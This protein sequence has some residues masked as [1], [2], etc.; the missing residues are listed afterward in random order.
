MLHPGGCWLFCGKQFLNQ[1]ISSLRRSDPAKER[2]AACFSSGQ[3]L[4]KAQGATSPA[5]V[6]AGFPMARQHPSPPLSP[7]FSSYDCTRFIPDTKQKGAKQLSV[8][9][10]GA[11]IKWFAGEP[12]SATLPIADGS[13]CSSPRDCRVTSRSLRCP[14]GP[15]SSPR[16]WPYLYGPSAHSWVDLRRTTWKWL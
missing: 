10:L 11:N 14:E 9:N 5:G 2:H 12:W 13:P 6:T 7:P 4:W 16:G 8:L 15:A 1:P 3:R